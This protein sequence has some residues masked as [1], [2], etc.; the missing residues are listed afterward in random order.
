MPVWA[1]MHCVRGM[2]IFSGT[3]LYFNFSQGIREPKLTDEFGSLYDFLEQY[4][5]QATIQQ[6]HISP[7]QGPTARTWEG[8]GEQA[9]W[10]QHIL[11]RATYFH[12]EFGREIERVG[13]GLIPALF[14]NLTPSSSN[15]WRAT[16]NNENAYSL[17]L[18][19]LAF[20]AQGVETTV[21]SGIGKNIF[22]RGGYTYLDSVVQRSFSSDNA[23]AARRLSGH[24]S[25]VFQWASTRR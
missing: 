16:L 4:G 8:G 12:N 20:R 18:N 22:F 23:G 14:P 13:A 17:D 5:G 9:F 7:L 11:F 24:L 1:S 25:T 2:G 3:R 6:L 19:S 15:S 21:E 10:S